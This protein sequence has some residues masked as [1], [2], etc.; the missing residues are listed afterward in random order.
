MLLDSFMMVFIVVNSFAEV[1][2]FGQILCA[3]TQ[4]KRFRYDD[5]GMPL[6]KVRETAC[7]NCVKDLK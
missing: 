3:V 4:L 6:N 5:T 2:L 7:S 1:Q